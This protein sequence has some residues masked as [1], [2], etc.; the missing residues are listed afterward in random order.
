[1]P[2]MTSVR[3]FQSV[4]PLVVTSIRLSQL[5]L[6]FLHFSDLVRLS[7]LVLPPDDNLGPI[8]PVS[9]LLGFDLGPIVPVSALLGYDLGPIVP[10][11]AALGE[12]CS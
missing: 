7:R 10:V 8:A 12:N 1:M 3:L 6:R 9:A 5:V 11:H 2:M 4:L